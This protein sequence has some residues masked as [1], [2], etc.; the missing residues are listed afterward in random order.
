VDRQCS[1]DMKRAVCLVVVISV[2]LSLVSCTTVESF[3][4]VWYREVD[5]IRDVFQ[6]AE[7][8]EGK[9][10]VV[11]KKYNIEKDA[12]EYTSTG[13]YR[14]SGKQ[15]I[16]DYG[17]VTEQLTLD[18]EINGNMLSLSSDSVSIRLIKYEL[19]D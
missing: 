3:Y 17:D 15:I 1:T 8:E 7:N 4:G 10:T 2:L 5:G 9:A 14:V 13:Y 19:D 6:F 18:Y 11:W 12:V 16:F